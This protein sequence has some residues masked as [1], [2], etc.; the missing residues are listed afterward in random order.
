[1]ADEREKSRKHRYQHKAF[2]WSLGNKSNVQSKNDVNKHH[3]ADDYHRKR[4][5]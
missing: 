5:N 3:N 1:M 2:F 4:E